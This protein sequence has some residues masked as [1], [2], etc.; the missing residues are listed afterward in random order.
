MSLPKTTNK[1]THFDGNNPP[2][3]DFKFEVNS[4]GTPPIGTPPLANFNWQD[5]ST[6]V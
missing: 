1:V 4:Q 6:V 2:L 5:E 3:A